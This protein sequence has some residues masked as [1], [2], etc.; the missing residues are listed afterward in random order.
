L[1]DRKEKTALG[2][3]KP[4]IGALCGSASSVD[5]E[6]S[7]FFLTLVGFVLNSPSAYGYATDADGA[8]FCPGRK[9][10]LTR[11]EAG[12]LWVESRSSRYR[13]CIA[14]GYCCFVVE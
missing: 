4:L 2:V 11:H 9:D 8:G 7:P 6:Q 14:V 13:F 3:K 1:P 5:F 12:I 10:Y